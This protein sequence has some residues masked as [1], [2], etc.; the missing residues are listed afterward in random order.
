[1]IEQNFK[2]MSAPLGN[3]FYKL[4]EN[5]GRPRKYQPAELWEKLIDYMEWLN[6]NPYQEEKGFAYMGQVTKE[7]F[8]KLHVPTIDGFCLFAGIDSKTWR[9][10]KKEENYIP[11]IE[12]IKKVI[13]EQKFTAAAADLV[14]ANII[15]RELGLAE[16]IK[17]KSATLELN[18]QTGS[19]AESEVMQEF[20][21]DFENENIP[22]E[23]KPDEND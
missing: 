8:N 16:H 22:D 4:V 5:P 2:I 12:T 9:N 7:S 20:F 1:M 10:Y 18:L 14:N 6:D 3:Q 21:Q 19:A 13:Y 17:Q 23:L 15:S 11:I